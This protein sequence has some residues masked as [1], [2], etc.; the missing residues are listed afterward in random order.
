MQH[1]Q[2]IQLYLQLTTSYWRKPME[3]SITQLNCE[4]TIIN[5]VYYHYLNVTKKITNVDMSDFDK[6]HENRK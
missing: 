2:L 1:I 5:N 4:I 3:L 6:G